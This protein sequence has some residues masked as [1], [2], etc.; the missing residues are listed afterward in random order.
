[1]AAELP[2]EG[3]RVD[4]IFAGGDDEA[5]PGSLAVTI[6]G[7]PP[8]EWG[9]LYGLTRA[10]PR[11]GGKWPALFEIGSHARLVAE[12]WTMRVRTL[13]REPERYDFQLVGS[14]TG[15]DGNGRSDESFESRSGRVVL[16]PSD[17]GVAYAM[18]LAGV[19]SVPDI[20]E[21]AWHVVPRYHDR[22]G[23]P[24][25]GRRGV[26]GVLTVAQGLPNGPHVLEL[27]GS[28]AGLR[29]L[30]TYRPPLPPQTQAF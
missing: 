14:V 23:A 8:S 20:F 19:A 5:Q 1:L 7:K 30:R 27:R 4:A 10:I 15:F 25:P 22:I 3:N 17:W 6:D 13:S 24:L 16:E 26:E 12:R 11:P 9:E 21:I 2:F 28:R 29:R 18:K